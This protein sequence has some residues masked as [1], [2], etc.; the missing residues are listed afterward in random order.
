M[1]GYKTSND[2]VVLNYTKDNAVSFLCQ[3]ML[4]ETLRLRK[5]VRRKERDS[6][7]NFLTESF[8]I[9]VADTQDTESREEHLDDTTQG[10]PMSSSIM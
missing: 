2:S 10:I 3:A 6:I 8:R 4:D 5:C 9:L 7:R 1:I